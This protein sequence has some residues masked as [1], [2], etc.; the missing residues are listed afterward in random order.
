MGCRLTWP[1]PIDQVERVLRDE[2]GARPDERGDLELARGRDDDLV[3]VAE[4]LDDVLLVLRDDD[5]RQLLAPL[6]EHRHGR[7]RRRLRE[8]GAVEDPER[9][10]GGVLRRARPAA[11]RGASCDSPSPRNRA[12]SAGMQRRRRSSA[13]RASC[14]RGR[15]RCPSGATASNGRRRRARGSSRHACRCGRAFSSARTVSWTMC[16][17]ISAANTA[18][19]SV[20]SFAFLPA[21][22]SRGA[23]GAA[24]SGSPPAP[25]Q[26]RSSGPARRP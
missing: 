10:V 8:T 6:R 9:A 24:T 20:T 16:G 22:S 18:S 1:S 2:H 7:S 3:D 25:G 23:F 13:A 21:M 19:S 12:A 5:E 26:S 11:R 4:R 17:F 15:G 14:P